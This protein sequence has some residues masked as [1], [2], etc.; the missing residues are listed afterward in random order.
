MQMLRPRRDFGKRENVAAV[1]RDAGRSC[2]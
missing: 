1:H 2:V